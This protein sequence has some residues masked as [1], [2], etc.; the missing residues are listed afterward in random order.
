M[1]IGEALSRGHGEARL[2]LF[3]PLVERCCFDTNAGR[4]TMAGMDNRVGWQ[5]EQLVFD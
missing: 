1:H 5:R 4:V 3:L 2:E